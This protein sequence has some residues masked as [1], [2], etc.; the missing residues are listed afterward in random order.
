M[1]TDTDAMQRGDGES[2]RE[3]LERREKIASV[4]ECHATVLA[5]RIAEAN[6][7]IP[8]E[9]APPVAPLPLAW[10]QA[11]PE[12]RREFWID[13]QMPALFPRPNKPES[14]VRPVG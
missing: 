8:A 3:Y 14:G 1:V 2:A 13:L 4:S 10:E 9:E 5:S 7:N 6:A 12:Q 11:T